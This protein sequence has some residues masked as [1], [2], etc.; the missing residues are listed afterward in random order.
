MSFR[1]HRAILAMTMMTAAVASTR[2]DGPALALSPLDE[3]TDTQPHG[4]AGSSTGSTSN[5][6]PKKKKRRKNKLASQ[7][8]RRN[9]R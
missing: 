3:R 6:T 9:R 5:L 1:S 2:G 4:H 7:S 8:R